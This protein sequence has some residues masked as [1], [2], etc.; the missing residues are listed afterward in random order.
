ME[1]KYER[2]LERERERERQSQKEMGREGKLFKALNN[3]FTALIKHIE[4]AQFIFKH[5]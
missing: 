5:N 3:C 4:S 2:A 1:D